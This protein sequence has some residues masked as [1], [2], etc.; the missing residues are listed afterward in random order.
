[1]IKSVNLAMSN[2]GLVFMELDG[3]A[4][5]QVALRLEE[6]QCVIIFPNQRG[7]DK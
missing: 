1:M 4:K 3:N 7:F 6:D 5:L 2:R